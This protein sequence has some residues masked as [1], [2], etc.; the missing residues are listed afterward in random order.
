MFKY[1]VTYKTINF[2]NREESAEILIYFFYFNNPEA[3]II[4]HGLEEIKAQ[5]LEKHNLP[6]KILSFVR[7]SY[8]LWDR[9][10]RWKNSS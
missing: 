6:V 2:R 1:K 4:L 10:K 5:L 3:D 9:F 7:V 8:T